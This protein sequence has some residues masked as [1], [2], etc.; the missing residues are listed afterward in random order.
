MMLV[1]TETFH[2]FRQFH[3]YFLNSEMTNGFVINVTDKTDER[4]RQ[5]FHHLVKNLKGFRF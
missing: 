1:E 4:F 5:E 2:Q 3:H